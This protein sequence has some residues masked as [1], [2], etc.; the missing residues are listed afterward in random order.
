MNTGMRNVPKLWREFGAKEALHALWEEMPQRHA[1]WWGALLF[2]SGQGWLRWGMETRERFTQWNYDPPESYTVA[3]P[4]R[5]AAE[6]VRF[7]VGYGS[8]V[9]LGKVDRSE[10]RNLRVVDQ[11]LRDRDRMVEW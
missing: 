2:E 6:Q 7:L 3:P 5:R 9:L 1:D 10:W 4:I 8:D 11:C